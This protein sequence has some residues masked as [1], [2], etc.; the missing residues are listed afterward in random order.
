M[1][2]L[3]VSEMYPPHIGGLQIHVA[4]LA[5]QLSS[6]GHI[7]EV[8]TLSGSGEAGSVPVHEVASAVSF[9]RKEQHRHGA[10]FHP[11][12]P[13]PLSVWSLH[14]LVSRFRPDVIH[15][16]NWLAASSLSR[17]GAKLVLTVHDY[18][19]I[20]ARRDFFRDGLSTCE[21]PSPS[22]CR[23]CSLKQMGRPGQ[24]VA[25]TIPFGR[26]MLR[27]SVVLAVSHA[28]ARRLKGRFSCPV[29]VVPNF[30][31]PSA[32][33]TPV[34]VDVLLPPSPFVMYA[35]ASGQHKG[36]DILLDIWERNELPGMNLLIATPRPLKADHRGV[37]VRRLSRQEVMSAWSKAMV[38]IVP[39]RWEEPC[40]TV[41]IEAMTLG[42][43]VVASNVGGIPDLIEPGVSG[44]LVPPGDRKSLL[45]ALRRLTRDEQLRSVLRD[46]ARLK[47]SHFHA[48]EVV[49][50]LEE[51]YEAVISPAGVSGT[52]ASE[53][54]DLCV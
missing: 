47:A 27:P 43:P 13:D 40:P 3:L 49:S 15:A 46:G 2:V 44:L 38:A 22:R 54:P 36:T 12:L 28:V 29:A 21:G 6:R 48:A 9:L 18:E 41:V 16:H 11:P 24:L 1:R 4:T 35:G 52:W 37:V 50:R 26:R 30:I 51:I 42:V 5:D 20:C 17:H 23:Y 34:D 14:R 39:S 53:L 45:H 10:A 32:F 25:A 31:D 19:F 8:A 33:A 7:V